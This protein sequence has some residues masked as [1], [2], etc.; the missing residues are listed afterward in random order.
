MKILVTHA[1]V[2]AEVTNIIANVIGID[3]DEISPTSELVNDLGAESLDFVEFNANLEKRFNLTLPKKGTLFQAGKITESTEQFYGG[4][5][6][7]TPEGVDL[8]AHSLSGYEH[9][10][11]GL[12][13]SD[14][15][16]STQVINIANLCYNLLNHYLPSACSECGHSPVKL[17]PL[18]KLQCESCSAL[19][20]PLHGDEAEEKAVRTYLNAATLELEIA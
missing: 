12:T 13:I 9:L 3:A 1:Y 14:I 10:Q 20:R 15:F 8:L 7:L 2:L 16:N 17:S 11:P 4:K 6:G 19:V 5:T 18:G